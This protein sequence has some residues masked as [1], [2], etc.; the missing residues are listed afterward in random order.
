M[1]PS[2][3]E[4]T[5]QLL[6]ARLRGKG[7][8][9]ALAEQHL[10]LVAA[11]VRRFPN[12]YHEKEEL[13]QQGCIG[14]M[15][16]LTRFDP[17]YGTAFST[18]AA[19]MILG[20]MRSLCR[21]EAPIHVPRGDR[22]LRSRIRQA[23]RMLMARL[24][25]EATVQELAAALRTDPAELMLSMEQISILS[26]DTSSG[27]ALVDLLP[28]QTDWEIRLF[29]RDLLN[30]LPKNDQRLL[31]LRLRFGKTQAE[32]ARVL[33]MTQVQ[34]SRREQALKQQLRQAWIAE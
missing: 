26:V 30:R 32:T 14:L 33:G 29:L 7:A 9:Q 15:K 12:D 16:A 11:M 10:P 20:E 13:Y 28:D 24:G 23:Q 1:S 3:N 27:H 4:F 5:A 18:Y 6:E 17:S 8:I 34:V 31:M 19:S 22:E 2:S 21:I 25:R